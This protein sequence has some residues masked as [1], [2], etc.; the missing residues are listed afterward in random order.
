MAL[1]ERNDIAVRTFQPRL[2]D[3]VDKEPLPESLAK[4]VADVNHFLK[5]SHDFTDEASKSLTTLIEK[6]VLPLA[7]E[8]GR[9]LVWEIHALLPQVDQEQFLEL[10]Q[11]HYGVSRRMLLALQKCAKLYSLT[12]YSWGLVELESL[13]PLAREMSEWNTIDAAGA[14]EY[15]CAIKKVRMQ[16][17]I[18]RQNARLLYEQVETGTGPL[19]NRQQIVL[20]S[21]DALKIA[22]SDQDYFRMRKIFRCIQDYSPLAVSSKPLYHFL[23][24]KRLPLISQGELYQRS[25]PG[26]TIRDHAL[27]L[28]DGLTS[29]LKSPPLFA[30][31][32][33]VRRN[34]LINLLMQMREAL[35]LCAYYDSPIV[36]HD[37]LTEEIE[38][39]PIGKLLLF[40][41]G[42]EHHGALLAIQ[43]TSRSICRVVYYNTGE[44]LQKHPIDPRTNKLQTHLVYEGVPVSTL[45]DRFLWVE[46]EEIK[47][48]GTV[49][50]LYLI[51]DRFA[52]CGK[53]Q[54]PSQD[55]FDYEQPQLQGT[56]TAQCLMAFLRHQI[57]GI[58]QGTPFEKQGVYKYLKAHILN[59][60][61][62]ERKEGLDETLG[63]MAE[64]QCER[65]Q[66]DL[67]LY[68][69]CQSQSDFHYHLDR[70][71]CVLQSLGA[72]GTV[73]TVQGLPFESIFPRYTSLRLAHTLLAS[74]IDNSPHEKSPQQDMFRYTNSLLAKKNH[75]ALSIRKAL[76]REM[77]T[78]E[79]EE[80][81]T[82]FK[83]IRN[84]PLVRKIAARF[85]DETFPQ[86]DKAAE[87]LLM[88][89]LAV[90]IRQEPQISLFEDLIALG[91]R[92]LCTILSS[93]GQI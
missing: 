11:K 19:N 5:T 76:Q 69:T 43:K 51:L 88:M 14:A 20:T 72:H 81:A 29:L 79:S 41:V 61:A 55:I 34:R 49:E 65:I 91:R 73:A 18:N 28:L 78:G 54:E 58:I 24:D 46:L 32:E 89:K 9:P 56:C 27:I 36:P 48:H 82:L 13:L 52:L 47:Q 17:F 30:I 92:D 12:L 21:P 31:F 35:A 63:E 40:P 7:T 15:I 26:G 3:P 84:Y 25:L 83:R 8:W 59:A 38:K 22:R 42:K 33:T 70:I 10:V 39:A 6:K 75:N 64:A 37:T 85:L 53:L 62:T 50:E 74:C 93:L 86:A 90:Q 2:F 80:F 67:K 4:R 87:S 60:I 77:Q 71:V 68:E 66:L 1:I 44:G 16:V 57:R 45:L 23:L